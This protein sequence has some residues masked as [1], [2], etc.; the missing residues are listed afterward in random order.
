MGEARSRLGLLLSELKRRRVF[1]VA[2]VYGVV[3]WIVV[4]VAEAVFPAFL[5]PD[6]GFRLVV[7]LALLGLPMA[8]ALA[9]AFD[10]TSSGLLRTWGWPTHPG[11]RRMRAASSENAAGPSAGSR[12]R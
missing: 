9:W 11:W 2:A 7:L 12:G 4:Q 5:I 10:I 1:R 6:W 3:A 8:L